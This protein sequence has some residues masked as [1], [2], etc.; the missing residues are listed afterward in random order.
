MRARYQCAKV[1]LAIF[2]VKN[3]IF[4]IAQVTTGSPHDRAGTTETQGEP[5]GS[6]VHAQAA[7]KCGWGT[8]GL[9]CTSLGKSTTR[10]LLIL[11]DWL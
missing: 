8:G 3:R 5:V 1:V 9:T 11:L 6:R 10:P 2:A 7:G 4:V